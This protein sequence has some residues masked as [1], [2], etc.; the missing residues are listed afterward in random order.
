MTR[1]LMMRAVVSGMTACGGAGSAGT[2]GQ[3]GSAGAGAAGSG[4]ASGL[5]LVAHTTLETFLPTLSD[6]TRANQPRGDTD[7]AE[8]F[9]RTQVDYV[10]GP[11]GLGVEIRTRITRR[12]LARW[13]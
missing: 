10:R 1:Q 5:T 2:A 4:P 12:S 8:S 13:S 3:A 6:W 11:S 7:T 9:S